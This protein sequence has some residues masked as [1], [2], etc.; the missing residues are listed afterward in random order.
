MTIQV[1]EETDTN[2]SYEF[3]VIDFA[4]SIDNIA[5]NLNNNDEI[6]TSDFVISVVRAY[7]MQ[8]DLVPRNLLN[9]MASDLTTKKDELPTIV[10]YTIDF[11]LSFLVLTHAKKSG[12]D[13]DTGNLIPH[14]NECWTNIINLMQSAPD[15]WSEDNV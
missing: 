7:G 13:A 8:E 9:K 2:I 12:P 10:I 11:A 5:S 6:K 15:D 1:I 3:N 4:N 14:M